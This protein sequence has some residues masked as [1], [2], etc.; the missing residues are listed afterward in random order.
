MSD[1]RYRL[2][3]GIYQAASIPFVALFT[4]DPRYLH[5]A[6]RMTLWR[7]LRLV[8]RLWRNTREV[9]TGI[10]YKAHAAMAAKLFSLPPEQPGVVVECGCWKG[11]TSA[12]LSII[13]GIAGRNLILYDSFAGLPAPEPGDR[14]ASA[15]T[16]GHYHGDLDTVR[17]NV[18]R[19]GSIDRCEFR[20]GWFQDTLPG[21]SEPIVLMYLDVD[22][23]R[24]LH[25]CVVNL[26]GHLADNGF[27]FIDEFVLLDY[28]GLFWSESFWSTYFNTTPPG[29]VGSGSGVGVGQYYLGPFDWRVDPTSVAYTSKAFSGYWGFTPEDGTS[30]G[31]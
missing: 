30:D 28:C 7:R 26:W 25:D 18:A 12:N 2:L 8:Y 4:L 20:K 15:L 5:R 14:Y 11:G 24:S 21:H 1:R 13:C 27:C 6:Y 29:L 9:E 22:Y 17:A 10:S 3:A 19:L 16:E 23:Q 31:S